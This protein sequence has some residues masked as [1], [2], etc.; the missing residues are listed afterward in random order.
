MLKLQTVRVLANAVTLSMIT[1]ANTFLNYFPSTF[2]KLSF[3]QKKAFNM[4]NKDMPD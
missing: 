3:Q 1:S 4:S 2:K